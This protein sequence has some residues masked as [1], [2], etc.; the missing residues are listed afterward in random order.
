[1]IR[2]C[3]RGDLTNG[4]WARPEP[5]LPQGMKPGRPP[6]WTRRQLMDGIRWRTRTG[7]PRSTP[8]L[9]PTE[10]PIRVGYV[11]AGLECPAR[12]GDAEGDLDWVVAV[13]SAIVRA[14]QHAAG[15]RK[16]KPGH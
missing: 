2:L 14:H 10:R 12:P 16:R 11:G 1:M 9:T 8:A 15:A 13:D 3:G 7:A 4:Q 5:L 6:V